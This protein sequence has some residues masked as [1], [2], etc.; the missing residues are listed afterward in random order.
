M[1]KLP[2]YIKFSSYRRKEFQVKTLFLN[3]K[4]RILVKKYPI[5]KNGELFI[6]R[7]QETYKRLSEQNLPLEISALRRS[8]D[9]SIEFEY[10]K[11]H[12]LLAEL[13]NA[14]T[15][16]LKDDCLRVFDQF[17]ALIQKFPHR[18]TT[19]SKDFMKVFG[20]VPANQIYDTLVAGILDLNLDNLIKDPSSK[21]ILIDYEWTFDF[22][23]PK[24]YVLYRAIFYSFSHLSTSLAKVVTLEEIEKKYNFTKKEIKTYLEWEIGFQK[25]VSGRKSSLEDILN[26]RLS[27]INLQEKRDSIVIK[28]K[29]LNDIKE[30]LQKEINK[31]DILIENYSFELDDYRAFK[32][33]LLWRTLTQYRRLKSKIKNYIKI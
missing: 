14:S 19:L 9:N 20:E 32:K 28:S 33:G 8:A 15:D 2:T 23:I 3:E 7:W 18:K 30:K 16:Q 13:K 6:N 25:Y 29:D 11:G 17:Y 31:R 1:S 10:I 27:L 21:L 26:Q 24:R 22:P 12:S 5:Y 4:N